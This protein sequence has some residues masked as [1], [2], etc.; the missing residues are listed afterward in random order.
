MT[1]GFNFSIGR[2]WF[3]LGYEGPSSDPEPE[4]GP[5]DVTSQVGFG[6]APQSTTLADRST[7]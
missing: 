2:F 7:T 1:F 4:D 3:R 5:A 6:P